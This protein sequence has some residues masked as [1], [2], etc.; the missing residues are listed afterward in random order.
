MP[1]SAPG[2]RT[3]VP[4]DST[5][6]VVGWSR[7]ATMRSRVD[8]PQPEGPSSTRK[9]WSSIVSE[10][11]SSARV[12][13][14]RPTPGK[15]RLTPSISRPATT[16]GS[17][18]TPG[19]QPA[20]ELLEG[21]VGGEADQTDDH[22]AEDDLARVEQGLAVGDHVAD[23]AGGADQL[24][25]DDVRPRPA[26]HQAERLGDVGGARGQEHAAHDAAGARAQ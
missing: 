4:S 3:G 12:G 8:L 15:V 20:V 11:G 23:A 17:A 13:G 14:R 24:G 18:E 10:V 22:D 26:E 2:P 9:S 7:P 16:P 6:P 19:E 5:R 1:R 25:H 21:V